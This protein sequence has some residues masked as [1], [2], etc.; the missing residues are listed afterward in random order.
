MVNF[1]WRVKKSVGE[2]ANPSLEA[3]NAP[4]YPCIAARNCQTRLINALINLIHYPGKLMNT[5]I[6]TRFKISAI[7]L[8][9]GGEKIGIER[10]NN[11]QIFVFMWLVL[12]I[13]VKRWNLRRIFERVSDLAE[14]RG[15]RHRLHYTRK[16]LKKILERVSEFVGAWMETFPRNF[17][18]VPNFAGWSHDPQNGSIIL[19]NSWKIFLRCVL[20]FVGRSHLWS[21]KRVKIMCGSIGLLVNRPP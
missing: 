15:N 10:W 6:E 11:R 9:V 19:E 17:E 2:K 3:Q 12:I 14:D 4:R 8:S 21:T 16:F 13:G 1:F 5:K 7:P 18:R 20:E